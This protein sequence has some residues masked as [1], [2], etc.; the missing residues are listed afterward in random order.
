[1]DEGALG[2]LMRATEGRLNYEV[3]EPPA[4][5]LFREG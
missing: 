2:N 4:E 3:L 5:P 1:M